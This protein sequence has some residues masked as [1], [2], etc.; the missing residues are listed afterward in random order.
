MVKV[1]NA[2]LTALAKLTNNTDTPNHF[3][4]MALGTGSGA[5][6][7]GDT[8]LGTE[9][10]T[11]GGERAAATCSYEADYKAKWVHT[12]TFT[13]DL[14]VREMGILNDDGDPAGTL[15]LRHVWAAVKNVANEE[16]M[17]ITVK[18]AFAEAT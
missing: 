14:A 18:L 17:Q 16:T 12:F 6:A 5:E 1:T 8:T 7:A 13:G 9:I 10:V 11:N 4:Y 3:T 2:G 15:L